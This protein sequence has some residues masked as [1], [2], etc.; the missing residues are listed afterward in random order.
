VAFN[1][2]G[3]NKAISLSINDDVL[4]AI[5]RIRLSMAAGFDDKVM[6]Q[7]LNYAELEGAMYLEPYMKAAAPVGKSQEGDPH[8]GRLANSIVSRVGKYNRPSAIVGIYPGRN[9]DDETGAYYGRAVVSGTGTQWSKKGAVQARAALRA[10]WKAQDKRLGMTFNN[11]TKK[12]QAAVYRSRL[13]ALGLLDTYEHK[14][15]PS[16]PFI[17]NAAKDHRRE[18]IDVV[19]GTL[20]DLI[21]D[22][23]ARSIVGAIPVT[24]KGDRKLIKSQ[25][26]YA[27]RV[28]AG[29]PV[30]P[31]E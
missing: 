28:S 1:L 30:F 23:A 15:L 14:A 20:I 7:L 26:Q 2:F 5:D 16:R 12:R 17:R 13:E 8:P 21:N 6:D 9:R 11:A 27:K 19:K 3:S 31:G 29:Y 22:K 18:V 4:N 25:Q 10:R 24:A